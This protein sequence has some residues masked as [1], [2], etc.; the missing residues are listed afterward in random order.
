[1]PGRQAGLNTERST[2]SSVIGSLKMFPY[3]E[4]KGEDEFEDDLKRDHNF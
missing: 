4:D 2:G 1:M 3:D